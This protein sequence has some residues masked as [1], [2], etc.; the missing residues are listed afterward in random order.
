MHVRGPSALVPDEKPTCASALPDGGLRASVFAT[1]AI[2]IMTAAKVFRAWPDRARCSP[3]RPTVA[4]GLQ[5]ES[6]IA[7][8]RAPTKDMHLQRRIRVARRAY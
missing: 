8:E 4:R 7:R 3:A 6:L 5:L 1:I 2:E